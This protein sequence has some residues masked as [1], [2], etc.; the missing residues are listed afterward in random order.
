M[1]CVGYI[2]ICPIQS[3]ILS[4]R[5]DGIQTNAHVCFIIASTTFVSICDLFSLLQKIK[6]TS[7]FDQIQSYDI[8]AIR[9][10][11]IKVR[12]SRHYKLVE[13]ALATINSKRKTKKERLRPIKRAIKP[14]VKFLSE[15]AGWV[16]GFDLCP[17]F[18][19]PR[20]RPDIGRNH[21]SQYLISPISCNSSNLYSI[22]IKTY[23][24]RYYSC[25]IFGISTKLIV[26]ICNLPLA[27]KCGIG[28]VFR[29]SEWRN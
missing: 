15:R 27:H 28:A 8:N 9:T 12:Q 3:I 26:F 5:A 1:Q 10:S 19:F 17:P 22:E 23:L 14:P 4:D 2:Y 29:Q 21:K 11:L 16:P 24:M 6:S 7:S 25:S 13:V 20:Q 18:A